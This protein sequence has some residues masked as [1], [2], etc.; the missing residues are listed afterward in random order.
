LPVHGPA[1]R[2][3]VLLQL[4]VFTTQP[5]AFGFRATQILAQA[6]DFAPLLGDDLVRV[7]R[8]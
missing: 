7:T 6:V 1:R 4:V 5:L 3:E 2:L 8:R